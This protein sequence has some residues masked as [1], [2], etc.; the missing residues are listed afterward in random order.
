MH[1]IFH[2]FYNAKLIT[3]KTRDFSGQASKACVWV[4]PTVRSCWPNTY[5]ALP[6]LESL[7]N[8]PN[9]FSGVLIVVRIQCNKPTQ[10]RNPC[11]FTSHHSLLPIHSLNTTILSIFCGPRAGQGAEVSENS[12]AWS[13][14]SWSSPNVVLGG[15]GGKE[16]RGTKERISKVNVK[17]CVD[18]TISATASLSRMGDHIIEKRSSEKPP[19]WKVPLWIP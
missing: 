15:G 8:W 13:L 9:S 3:T 16:S 1:V 11:V 6:K 5:H 4:M 7:E 19:L 12:Q 14:S 2:N 18:W 10:D 17:N